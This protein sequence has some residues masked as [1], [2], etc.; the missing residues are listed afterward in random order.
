M[1]VSVVP[2]QGHILACFQGIE[3]GGFLIW[4]IAWGTKCDSSRQNSSNQDVEHK[5]IKCLSL[6]L[7]IQV[8][9]RMKQLEIISKNII[10]RFKR[11]AV[12]EAGEIWNLKR[13]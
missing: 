8:Y 5:Q 13:Q 2:R 4:Q 9:D 7:E 1:R 12:E 6:E 11:S 10:F 3:L